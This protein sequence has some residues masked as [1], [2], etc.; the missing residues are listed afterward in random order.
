MLMQMFIYIAQ[1]SAKN[2]TEFNDEYNLTLIHLMQL[3]LL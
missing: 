1:V 3:S 2:Q